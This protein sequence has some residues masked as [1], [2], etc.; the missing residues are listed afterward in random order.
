MINNKGY[1]V[2][3]DSLFAFTITVML[4]AG[5]WGAIHYKPSDTSISSF[6][7]L[8]YVSEDSLDVLNKKEILDEIGAAWASADGDN[9]SA[10]WTYAANLSKFY[11]EQLVPPNVGYRFYIENDVLAENISRSE[12]SKSIAKTN[13]IRLLV[14]YGLGLP[15]RGDVSRAFLT[16]IKSKTNSVYAFFGGF[17]GEGNLTKKITLPDDIDSIIQ[18]YLELNAGSEFELFVNDNSTGVYTPSSNGMSA[19]IKSH[20]ANPENQFTSGD[21]VLEFKFTGSD[22]S[23]QYIGGGFVKVTY[24]TSSMETVQDTGTGS[25]FFPGIYGLVN[26]YSSFYV[27][28]QLSNLSVYLHLKSNYTTYLTV[29]DTVVFNHTLNGGEFSASLYDE[30]LSSLSY[31]ELSQTTTP[32]RLGSQNLSIGFEGGNADVVLTT[33]LSFSMWQD[34][35]MEGSW[36]M[37]YDRDNP[38]MNDTAIA[39]QVCTSECV[40]NDGLL[41]HYNDCSGGYPECCNCVYGCWRSFGCGQNPGSVCT[42]PCYT[43]QWYG[44]EGNHTAGNPFGGSYCY[45]CT[46]LGC[47]YCFELDEVNEWCALSC[48]ENVYAYWGVNGTAADPTEPAPPG[49][50]SLFRCASLDRS[51]CWF[52]THHA[53]DPAYVHQHTIYDLGGL[54]MIEHLYC[55]KQCFACDLTG[56]GLAKQVDDE[57]T[58]RILNISGNMIGLVSYGDDSYSTHA[59]SNDSGSLSS[60]INSYFAGGET[61]ICCAINDAVTLFQATNASRLKFIVAMTDGEANVRCGNAESDLDGD[62][63]ITAKDDAIQSAC[64]AHQD[65]NITVHAVGFGSDAGLDTLQRIAT[66]GNGSYYVS[67]NPEEL[68]DIYDEIASQII[69]AVYQAQAINISMTYESILYPDSYIKFD[70]TPV[71]TTGYCEITL[72]MNTE[73]FNDTVDCSGILY[74]PSGTYVVDA[75]VTS[76]SSEYWTDYVGVDSGS[77]FEDA[78]TLRDSHFGS[79]YQILGDPFIVNIPADMLP[80]SINNTVLVETGLNISNHTGCSADDCVIYKIKLSRLV[81]YGDVFSKSEGCNWTI[82]FEDGSTMH[83]PIPTSYNGTELCYYTS[84]NSTGVYPPEDSY[85]D[86]VVRLLKQLDVDSDGRVD[87]VFDQSMIEFEF[88]RTGGVQSLWGPIKAKLILWM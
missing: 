10:N 88:G 70:Y 67:D 87:V 79:N 46:N 31:S 27:P 30:N 28:G 43:C 14:G 6:K 13:S 15:T 41:C 74:T 52:D 83:A 3:L 37:I 4:F 54:P 24:N 34:R 7:R 75:K 39:A 73:R 42:L 49:Q 32:I 72:S 48:G 62:S 18:A 2:I 84:I 68:E 71:N 78:Y 56:V 86:S 12:E 45:D 61:C 25:Y 64:T 38:A 20:I 63:Q 82:D 55:P 11:L 16:N 53:C 58:E 22:L 44:G 59:L 1:T 17:V 76:F 77:G 60:E 65:Y 9:S 40:R 19:N 33:D 36:H 8:H 50:C 80:S 23:T 66:C 81:G 57:F 35:C 85:S 5:L 47:T 69:E 26:Y 29:G 51:S 21:N